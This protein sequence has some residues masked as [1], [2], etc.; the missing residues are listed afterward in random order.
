MIPFIDAAE[1][2]I[3]GACILAGLFAAVMALLLLPPRGRPTST[4]TWPR[5]RAPHLPPWFPVIAAVCICAAPSSGQGQSWSAT[6]PGWGWARLLHRAEPCGR[7]AR[8]GRPSITGRVHFRT[9]D[10]RGRAIV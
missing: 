4:Q 5:R 1:I 3:I 10:G 6:E 7:D 2:A 9:C 8:S